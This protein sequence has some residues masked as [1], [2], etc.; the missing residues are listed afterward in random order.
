[1]GLEF[2]LLQRETLTAIVHTF[3]A[4]V[5]RDDDPTGFLRRQGQ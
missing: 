4:A 2:N 1:M 5:P 3:V